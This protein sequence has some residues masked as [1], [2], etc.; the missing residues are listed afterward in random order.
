[1]EDNFR[2]RIFSGWVEKY[3][4]KFNDATIFGIPISELNEDELRASICFQMDDGKQKAESK[5]REREMW[6]LF[7]RRK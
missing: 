1:M 6:K 5:S 2:E 7:N 3:R 4:D